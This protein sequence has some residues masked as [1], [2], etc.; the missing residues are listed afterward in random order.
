MLVANDLGYRNSFGNKI[1]EKNGE[2]WI[3]KLTHFGLR[4]LPNVG[5]GVSTQLGLKKSL[6]NLQKF[7]IYL[8]TAS[9]HV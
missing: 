4:V 7:S 6:T 5:Q 9:S 8:T 1:T 3:A 2:I